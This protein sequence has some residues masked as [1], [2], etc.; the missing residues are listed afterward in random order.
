METGVPLPPH[1]PGDGPGKDG[2]DGGRMFTG[3][4]RHSV[5]EKGRV[6][7]PARFRPQLD[8]GPV[9][10]KWTD[11]CAAVFPRAAFEQ[12]AAKVTVLP[13]ADERA[14]AVSR[15]L[16]ASAFEVDLDGQG[17]IVLPATVREWAALG[18]DAVVVGGWDHVEIWSPERWASFQ[19]EMESPD[20]LAAHLTGLGI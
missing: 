17:R 19:R 16:F 18:S 14:R 6:A 4:Y 15:F 20:A 3:E 12:L 11:G 9:V 5:D 8:K 10:A 1:G 7:I 2:R 13:I